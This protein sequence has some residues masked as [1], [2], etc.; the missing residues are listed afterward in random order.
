[1][2]KMSTKVIRS[3]EPAKTLQQ[4]IQRCVD[5]NRADGQPLFS[6][7][8]SGGSIPSV[9]AEVL[10]QLS[11]DFA[12]WRLFFCDE[13][14]V[15]FEDPESTCGVYR[16]EVMPRVP[17]L[18]AEQLIAVNPALSPQSAAE[19]YE[20]AIRR[21]LDCAEAEEWPRFDLL[22]LGMGPDGHTCSLFPNHALLQEKRKWV[23]FLTDSPKVSVV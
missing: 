8:L 5:R 16:R 7:G 22:L 13:R 20:R 4:L 11:S 10:P 17:A 12:K 19:D 1:M 21:S 6:V 14:L 18:A 23:S 3:E 9:L 15:P 2:Q